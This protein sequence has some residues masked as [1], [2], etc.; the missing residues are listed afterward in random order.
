MIHDLEL[1]E[2]LSA[3]SPI[4]F[5]GRV[6]RA[7]PKSLSPLTASVSGG[8]WM[9]KG[10]ASILYTSCEREG[11]LAELAFHWAQY[12]PLP[13]Y[14]ASL[15]G[16]S[17]TAQRTFRLLRADLE[18]LDVH[19]SK[20]NETDYMRTQQIGAAVAFLECDGL[21]VPSARWPCENLM[22]FMD[23]HRIDSNRLEVVSTE[24]VDWLSWARKNGIV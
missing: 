8:R 12:N 6:F 17:L 18:S 13:S 19:W 22:L 15:Y 20:Y 14:P 4:A 11:A 5:N 3:Y 10:G 21:I 9:P 7:T 16:I 1:V 24:E 23:H 2:R